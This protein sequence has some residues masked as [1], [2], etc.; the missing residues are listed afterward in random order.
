MAKQKTTIA[1]CSEPACSLYYTYIFTWTFI[2][3]CKCPRTQVRLAIFKANCCPSINL[4]SNLSPK[5]KN[6]IKGLLD[7]NLQSLELPIYDMTSVLCTWETQTPI[8]G[9]SVFNISVEGT[10]LCY[11]GGLLSEESKTSLLALPLP[12]LALP[13]GKPL[14]QSFCF[15]CT[16]TK[17][18][19]II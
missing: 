10:Q 18:N 19:V 6:R 9:L 12:L 1:F 4:L 17:W 15:I 8:P 2:Q 14:C 11:A 5:G 13:F 3:E 16:V 7:N